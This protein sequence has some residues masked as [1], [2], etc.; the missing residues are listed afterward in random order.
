MRIEMDGAVV[1]TDPLLRDR[2]GFLRRTS[3]VPH[4]I[5][6]LVD[7]VVI[8]HLH[9]DHLDLPSL[10][11]IPAQV[12]VFVPRGAA[13]L[14]RRAGPREIVEMSPGESA[15]VGDVQIHATE[16]VHDGSRGKRGPT[17]PPLGWIVS[18]SRR[19][20][21]AGDTDIFPGMA[22]LAPELDLAL[23][24]VWGW[25]PTLGPGHLDPPRGAEALRLLRPALAVPI[26]W[27][28]LHPVALP[29]R[30]R[31]YLTDPGPAF[32]EAARHAAPETQVRVI[33]P[34]EA[35]ETTC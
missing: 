8:S 25:G 35:V 33:R 18:G 13:A 7:A 28:T 31:G 27:G 1:L 11:R 10:R 26:H 23:I 30:M 19:V 21:F 15:R 16:A 17:G 12:P 34:G 4:G 29:R 6:D 5:A 24:P 2:V 14:V 3:E 9:R 20:Y 22:D 32:A